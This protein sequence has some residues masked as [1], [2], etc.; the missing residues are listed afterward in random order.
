MNESNDFWASAKLDT[1]EKIKQLPE[2]SDDDIVSIYSDLLIDIQSPD[3]TCLSAKEKAF[4]LHRK[5]PEFAIAYSGLFNVACRRQNPMSPDTVRTLLQVARDKKEG[6]IME[7]KAR[8]LVMDLAETSR[9][10]R[11]GNI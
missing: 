10:Q 3:I 5:Y 6:N 7:D 8:G 9:R 2:Y 11:D 1:L 4:T